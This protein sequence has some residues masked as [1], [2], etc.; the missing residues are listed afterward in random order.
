MKT[1][2][3]TGV[4]REMGLGNALVRK[5]LSE[6]YTV[7]ASARDV[8]QEHLLKLK[9]EWGEALYLIEM[10]VTKVSDVCAAVKAVH[11]VSPTL[12]I[13]I[14]NATATYSEGNKPID[15]GLDIEG[16]LNSYDVNAIGFIRLVQQF[17]LLDM[18][19][20]GSSAVA[21]SSEAGSM[22]DC[23][24]DDL[25]DYG[26]AK[27]ALNFACVTLQRRL[28]KHEIRVLSI[29]PG[30]VQTRPAPPKANLTPD[31]SAEHIF[32]TIASPPPFNEKGNTGVYMNYDGSHKAF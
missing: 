7:F 19:K 24:R 4:K 31:E 27:A 16:A 26:M 30:W 18:F 6:G 5:Y 29:H 9:D 21:I 1:V 14:S 15:D 13:L 3:I 11:E 25:I 22:G 8:E 28:G 12:D 20:A 2:F 23:W 17:L 32:N 10:D